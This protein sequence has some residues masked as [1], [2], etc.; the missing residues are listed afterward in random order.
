MGVSIGL[1][2]VSGQSQETL[3][4]ALPVEISRTRDLVSCRIVATELKTTLQRSI[5]FSVASLLACVAL[6]SVAVVRVDLEHARL[7]DFGPQPGTHALR[8]T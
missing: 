8:T 2:A 1:Q 3:T 5:V 7:L 4:V 6:L